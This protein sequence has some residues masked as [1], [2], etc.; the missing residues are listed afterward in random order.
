M[1]LERVSDLGEGDC[2]VEHTIVYLTGIDFGGMR[3]LSIAKDFITS[4]KVCLHENCLW[5]EF[6][7]FLGRFGCMRSHLLREDLAA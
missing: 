2:V 7:L 4:G 3:G 1:T 5:Q 6:L